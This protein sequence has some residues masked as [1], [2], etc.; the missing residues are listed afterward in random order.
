MNKTQYIR[1]CLVC[2]LLTLLLAACNKDW[3]DAKSNSEL[4]VPSTLTDMQA[5]MDNVDVMNIHSPGMGELASDGHYLTATAISQLRP[6]DL[7]AYTWSHEQPYNAVPDWN[8]VGLQFGSYPKILYCNLVLEGLDKIEPG[9]NNELQQWNDTRGQALFHRGRSFY[10]LAQVFAPAYNAATAATDLGIPLRLESDF[11]VPSTR[12]SVDQ[13]YRQIIR[14]LEEAVLL[15]P[16]AARYPT[17]GSKPAAF[18]LLAR[19][20]LVMENYEKAGVYADS[21]LRLYHTL[22]DYNTLDTASAAPVAIFNAETL[23]YSI[24]SFKDAFYPGRTLIEPALYALYEEDDLRK[25]IFFTKNNTTGDIAFKGCYTGDAFTL[26]S[27]IACD[28]VYLIR[29]ECFAR[30]NNISAGLADLNTLL[31]SRYKTGAFTDRTAATATELLELVLQERKK[32]LLLRGLR[33]S[34]LK[35]LNKDDRFKVSFSRIVNGKTYTLEPGSYKYTFPIPDDVI[36][37]SGMPQNPGWD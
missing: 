37:I 23:F 16:T 14:D 5:L 11:N 7:N 13:T 17:R 1:N 30:L 8:A 34:D 19:T 35:R 29:A 33:W 22:I 2:L 21:A 31:R 9:N 6:N 12:A 36:A 18:A 20:Y 26:F 4:A 10:E 27:G 24:L 25:K 32:E 15:L 3:Y 28:E